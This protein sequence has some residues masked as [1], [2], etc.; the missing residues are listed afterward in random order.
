M[1]RDFRNCL[2][3]C[4]LDDMGFIGDPFTW[5]RGDIR[6]RFDRA[7]CNVEWAHKF[8]RAA[9]INEEHVHSD[10]RPLVL[11]MNYFDGERLRKI[12]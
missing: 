3:E 6:E 4:D 10:Y 8:P 1:M 12:I 11:D 9:V 5:R 7:A 2:T